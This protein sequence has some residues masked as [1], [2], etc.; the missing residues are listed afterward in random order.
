MMR[1]FAWILLM[2]GLVLGARDAAGEIVF[3]RDIRPIFTAHCTACHGGVKAAGSVSFVVR[4]KALGTGQSGERTIVPGQPDLS[5]LMRRVTSKDPDEVMPQPDHGPPLS[6][7]DIATLRQWILEGAVWSEHW[8]LVPPVDPPAPVLRDASWT[9]MPLDAFVQV[10]LESAELQPSPPAGAAEWLRRVSLDLT[11]LPPTLEEFAT[12]KPSFVENVGAA[13]AAVVDRLLAS[14]AF[15]ERWAS[16]WLDLARYA[17]TYGFEKDPHRDIWPWRDWV[18][19][20]LNDDMPFDQFTIRQLAGDQVDQPTADDLLATAFHRNTQ[21]N[22]EGGTS[23]EEFRAAAVVDR[24]NTTW[25]A[26]Q[27]TTFGCVQCHAHPYDP[28]PHEDYYRFMALFDNTEDADLDND[29]PRLPVASDPARRDE[30]AALWRERHGVREAL[31]DRGVLTAGLDSA[32]QPL[33]AAEAQSSGGTLTVAP[34]GRVTASGTLP[35]GVQYTLRFPAVN[36][37]TALRLEIFPDSDDPKSWPERASVLSHVTAAVLWPD[38]TRHEIVLSEVIADYLAGPFDPQESLEG[39]VGGF[40]SF[41]SQS[42]GRWGVLVPGQAVAAPQ[43]AVLELTLKQSAVSNAN[44]QACT[45]RHFALAATTADHWTALAHDPDRRA[46]WDRFHELGRAIDAIP[47][48][49]IPVQAER[50]A[51]AIRDT[52]VWIRGNRLTKGESVTPGLPGAFNPPAADG[53]PRRLDFAR[54]MV[55]PRHPLTARVLAN[56]LWAGLFGTG[57]V[58]TLEDFG[59]SGAKP[60]NQELL[61]HLAVR[62]ASHHAWSIKGLL[63]E[64]ALSSTYAQTAMASSDLVARDPKNQL[65]ARGPRQRL[66]A[67]MVRDHALAVSGLL[68][69]KMFGPPVFPPQPEGVWNTVYS[70]AQWKTSEGEGRY[71]RA[72]YTYVRRTSGYPGFLMFDAPARDLCTAR[73]MPTNTPLQALVTLN[74]PAFIEMAAAL[75]ARMAKDGGT[76]AEQIARGCWLITLDGPPA[77]LV[78]TLV[79]LHDAALAD[80]RARP[81][82][83]AQLGGTPEVAALTLVANTLLNTDRALNR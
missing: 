55:D 43:G 65:L 76:P 59:S 62:L 15:G 42:G 21:N 25:T 44:Q 1:R 36:G 11:G 5:E 12:L 27:A 46:Q 9:V 71:R 78:T 35:V 13:R 67:E 57:I 60:S 70:G 10:R 41:P 7:K 18:I 73:R 47:H 80:Y 69:T 82:T 56:R 79:A 8:S 40:G 33:V 49:R 20:A 77:S 28:Y 81:E 38:R 64:I 37:L 3:N 26:W 16:V 61:D 19:R 4:E 22:T 17:D 50:N 14:P 63:R 23:D 83:A 34:D 24:V 58:E 2:A 68:S 75:A 32:W 52:R 48:T 45:L 39:G 74:D 53:R 31:N 72:V 29:F 6:G 51:K 30:L 66:T 54:W